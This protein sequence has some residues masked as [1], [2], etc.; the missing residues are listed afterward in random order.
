MIR[1]EL[2]AR[3]CH[4]KH[5]L[6]LVPLFFVVV[7][8]VI[9]HFAFQI[10]LT[11]WFGVFSFFAKFQRD[12]DATINFNISQYMR[13]V[14]T[15]AI[16]SVSNRARHYISMTIAAKRRN[17]KCVFCVL[18]WREYPPSNSFEI[19]GSISTASDIFVLDLLLL[20]LLCCCCCCDSVISKV[21]SNEFFLLVFFSRSLINPL[22]VA[23]YRADDGFS[24]FSIINFFF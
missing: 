5:T 9:I 12:D 22:T 13:L 24:S 11:N 1:W 16:N 7:V 6:N 21:K 20:W 23:F 2:T 4:I 8:A 19:I 15:I 10:Q 14:S 3:S 17:R 18:V